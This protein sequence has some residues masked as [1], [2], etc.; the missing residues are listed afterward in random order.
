MTVGGVAWA[1]PVKRGMPFPRKRHLVA[2]P[3]FTESRVS[4]VP[5]IKNGA[6]TRFKKAG[7]TERLKSRPA[8]PLEL[9]L[10]ERHELR[11]WPHGVI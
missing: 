11:A 2:S 9:D 5:H 7:G 4:L 3:F 6:L 1:L 10:P 8:R